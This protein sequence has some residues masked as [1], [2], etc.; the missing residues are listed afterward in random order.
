MLKNFRKISKNLTKFYK[1]FQRAIQFFDGKFF[2]F[3]PENRSSHLTGQSNS[4]SYYGKTEERNAQLLDNFKIE[5][6]NL[7]IENIEKFVLAL[8][9]E[10]RELFVIGT[11]SSSVVI[12]ALIQVIIEDYFQTLSPAKPSRLYERALKYQPKILHSFD[13]S[14]ENLLLQV[15]FFSLKV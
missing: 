6:P 9:T 3:L 13:N 7:I 14:A 15:R 1:K 2:H 4:L 11:V 5:T 8:V 10:I 12:N